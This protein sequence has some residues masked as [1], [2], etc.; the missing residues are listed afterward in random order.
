MEK[1]HWRTAFNSDYLGSCDVDE[2]DLVLTIKFVRIEEIKQQGG[3]TQQ[4]NVAHFHEDAKPMILNV[5]NSKMVKNFVNSKYIEEWVDVPVSIYVDEK[6]KVGH[7]LVEGLRIRSVQPKIGKPELLPNTPTWERAKEFI[8][9]GN[10]IEKIVSKY[11]INET[12]KMQLLKEV[13]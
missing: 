6:V 10:P 11:F 13:A 2:K 1:T 3:Y 5:T 9:S 4:C 12:N 7:E 8:A